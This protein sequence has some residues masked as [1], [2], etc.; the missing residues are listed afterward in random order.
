MTRG[1]TEGFCLAGEYNLRLGITKEL[2]PD[3]IATHEGD[4]HDR[5][6]LASAAEWAI[7]ISCLQYTSQRSHAAVN[8]SMAAQEACRSCQTSRCCP[9]SSASFNSCTAPCIC[10]SC[11]QTKRR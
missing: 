2:H 5:L 4:R 11:P 6:P 9:S 8:R 3:M 7:S 10:L 1:D